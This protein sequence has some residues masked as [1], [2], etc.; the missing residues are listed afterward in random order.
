MLLNKDWAQFSCNTDQLQLMQ[1]RP[2]T[3]YASQQL[4]DYDTQFM[5]WNQQAQTQE[6]YGLILF[7]LFIYCC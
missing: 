2:I 1:H 3:A 6:N 4:K 7:Y 5:T